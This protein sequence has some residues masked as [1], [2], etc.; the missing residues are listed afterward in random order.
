M[1]GPLYV[2]ATRVATAPSHERVRVYKVIR[3]AHLERAHDYTPASILFASRRY[4]FDD[5]LTAGLDLMECSIP[6]LFLALLRRRVSTLEVNEPLMR[7]GLPRAVAAVTAV[8]IRGLLTGRRCRVATYAIANFN[9]F[10]RPLPRWRSR[11]RKWGDTVLARCL[12]R[13]LDRIAYGT[14]GSRALYAQLL[15]AHL[16]RVESSLIPAL[17]SACTCR[18]DGEEPESVV[19]VGAFDDRKGVRSLMEAWPSVVEAHP[20]AQLEALGQG[21]HEEE[22][23]AFIAGTPGAKLSVDP[24]RE[25]IHRAL[26]RSAVLVLFSARTPVWREQVGL[27][28]VEGLAHGCHIVTSTET[29]LAPW[30]EEHGHTALPGS[31]SAEQLGDAIATALGATLPATSVL[32]SLPGVDGRRSADTWLFSSHGTEDAPIP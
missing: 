14:P 9:E 28:I 17:P 12:A 26:G 22:V 29:G 10:E 7:S 2:A 3:S 4:D 5:S 32:D 16:A 11:L 15:G 13:S 18:D 27:P 31:A 20:E 21:V 30:L 1:K 24:T 8:R 19:F 6:R 25:Q 23:R